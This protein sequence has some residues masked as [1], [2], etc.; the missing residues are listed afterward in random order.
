MRVAASTA[1]VVTPSVIFA[2]SIDI[3]GT[4][5]EK[6]FSTRSIFYMATETAISG[7]DFLDVFHVLWEAKDDNLGLY[8]WA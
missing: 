5:M 4:E 6:S 7:V 1:L 2:Y 8:M 3:I